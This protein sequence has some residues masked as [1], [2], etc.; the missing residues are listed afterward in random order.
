MRDAYRARVAA[1]KGRT[2]HALRR[3]EVDRMDVPIPREFDKDAVA[4]PIL[5][6][7]RMREQRGMKR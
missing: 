1:W 5:R 7:F 6:F 2:E 4:R 3:A